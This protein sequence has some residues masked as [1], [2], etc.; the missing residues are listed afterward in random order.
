MSIGA[1]T[2]GIL[3]VTYHI[4]F[5][6]AIIIGALV[7][8]L[9]GLLIGTPTL[10]LRGDYLA[11]ATLGFGEIIRVVFLDLK[12][13]GGTMGLRGIPRQS[14]GALFV[15]VLLSVIITA[16][17][18]YRLTRSR[19]G[20]ALIAIREDEIAAEAMGINTTRY[21]IL[22]FAVS[23]LFAGLAGGLYTIFYRYI[24][25]SS[26]GFLR[27]IEILCMVV[28]G[29]MG[30]A[31]GASVGA[32]VLTVVPE[33]LRAVAE[34]RQILYG[35]LLVVMMLVR[36][37]GLISSRSF[38]SGGFDRIRGTINNRHRNKSEMGDL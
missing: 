6:I 38:A 31:L 9:F 18:L 34:Y 20:R 19:V 1:F 4:P 13:T 7:A 16:L 10:R 35:V 37:Q 23:A 12:I 25:A 17:F 30:N 22:S 14:Q 29:G 2:S 36:P 32:G 33:I 8:G 3:I 26:F 27:S 5:V 21:K 15:V 11:I 24:N 28:L